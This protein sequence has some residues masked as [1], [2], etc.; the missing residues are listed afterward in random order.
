MPANLDPDP[1]RLPKFLPPLAFL[2]LVERFYAS[3]IHCASSAEAGL[4]GRLLYVGDFDGNDRALMVAANIAG[5]ASLAVTADPIEPKL[6]MQDGVADFLVNSLD[7][8]LRILKNEIRKREPVAVCVAASPALIE[9]EMLERGVMPDLVRETSSSDR[10]ELSRVVL[11]FGGRPT[12]V[13]SL[14]PARDES[15]ISWSVNEAPAKWLP[16]LD[17]IAMDFFVSDESESAQTARRW[18][19]LAPRY[20]G[21]LAGNLRVLRC[22]NSTAQDL[23]NRMRASVQSGAVGVPVRIEIL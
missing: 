14:A 10:S 5:A 13:A 18:L 11:F 22:P 9:Q 17:A 6:A 23:A 3:L 16:R 7:E 4:G 8:A 2:V 12:A 20:L 15:V 1:N 21:R 19:H